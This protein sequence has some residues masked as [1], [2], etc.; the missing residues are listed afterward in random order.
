M[1]IKKL[2][3]ISFGMLSDRHITFG[4]GLNVIEGENETGKSTV[5]AFIRFIFYGLDKAGREKYVGWG[6]TGCAGS[7]T[8]ESQGSE[9]RIEREL[10]LNRARDRISIFRGD[11]QIRTEKAPWELFIGAPENVFEN[12]AFTG[13][14]GS[15]VGGQGL[16][17]AIENIVFSADEAVSTK[18]ALKKLDD[19]RVALLYKNKKG[20]KIYELENGVS[21]LEYRLGAAK[22]ASEKIFSLDDSIRTRRAR[23]QSNKERIGLI[24][25]QLEDFETY[26][27]LHEIDEHESNLKALKSTDD[28]LK[29]LEN[30][31]SKN[32]F[33]PDREFADG[34]RSYQ[35]SAVELKENSVKAAA[36]LEKAAAEADRAANTGILRIASGAGGVEALRDMYEAF[37]DKMF[38]LGKKHAVMFVIAAALAIL[39]GVLAYFGYGIPY[40]LISGGAALIFLVIGIVICAKVS[41]LRNGLMKLAAKLGTDDPDMIPDILDSVSDDAAATEKKTGA[42][43]EARKNKDRSDERLAELDKKV[44]A[45]TGRYRQVGT[46]GLPSLITEVDNVVSELSNAHRLTEMAQYKARIS[47]ERVTGAD[48]DKLKAKLHGALKEAELESFNADERRTELNLLVRQNEAIAEKVSEEEQNFAAANATFTLPASIYAKLLSAREELEEAKTDLSAYALAYEKLS[49]ASAELRS[50]ISPTLAAEAG[51]YIKR[52]S[53]GKYEALGVSGKLDLTY[54]GGGMTRPASTM[55]SGTQD[56]AYVSLRLSL[57]KLVFPKGMTA[58]FDDTFARVDDRRALSIIRTLASSELQSVVFTCHE[59]DAE[60]AERSGGNVIRL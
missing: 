45:F 49:E 38:A 11:E 50:S 43:K 16:P 34:L 24:T 56:I 26:R 9:Y 27:R 13:E 15:V 12:T 4:D 10:L 32:G 1:L 35:A 25:S 2:H 41:K 46:D 14:L 42:Y 59:R 36:E 6:M 52:F 21:E 29:E 28:R 20:G 48:R 18:K 5:G 33:L 40:S 53:D 60:Y 31:Y 37:D 47:G 54:T 8:I 44:R 23:L 51:E 57:I 30:K 19:A 22:T 7:I 39:A 58:F 3:I 55:S 17:E